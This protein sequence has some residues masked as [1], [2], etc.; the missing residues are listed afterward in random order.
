MKSWFLALA[1]L[2]SPVLAQS[3][4]VPEG[5]WQAGNSL[6]AQDAV[7]AKM[8]GARVVLLGEQHAN[9]AIH[10]WQ[11]ATAKAL[12]DNGKS[13]VIGIEYLPRSMQPVLDEWVAG[14][15]T[16]EAFFTKSR[17]AELWK[18]DFAAYRPLFDLARERRVPMVALNVDRDFIRSVSKLGFDGAAA[19]WP[20]GAPIGKPAAPDAAY[21]ESLTAVFLQHAR[22]AKPESIARFIEAQTVWDRAFAEGLAA[23]VKANPQAIAIGV[24]GQG[25]VEHGY[26]TAHQLRALGVDDVLTAVPAFAEKPCKTLTDAADLLYG[27]N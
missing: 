7:V 6:L 19:A 15:L 1:L 17:W 4:C 16:P 10:A 26:G 13:V 12:L 21:V 9:P 11:A 3:V 24:M 27:I 22:E 23:A 2:A 8:A 20:G 18:H 14:R 25:H 5:R